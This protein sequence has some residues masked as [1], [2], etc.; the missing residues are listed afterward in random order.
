MYK[1]GAAVAGRPQHA[2][3]YADEDF[4]GLPDVSTSK[5]WVVA[6]LPGNEPRMYA[7]DDAVTP[8]EIK[9]GRWHFS[10]GWVKAPGFALEFPAAVDDAAHAL[11]S[12]ADER[13][14]LA[15]NAALIDDWRN[16]IRTQIDECSAKLLELEAELVQG[17]ADASAPSSPGWLTT[18]LGRD[19]AVDEDATRVT[20]TN[21]SSW[22]NHVSEPFTTD[23][24][25]LV[26]LFEID[27][28]P[29]FI[30]G[31]SYIYIYANPAHICLF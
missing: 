26:R 22:G 16:G 29:H 28:L 3:F 23:Q 14:A 9:K 5:K 19:I 31:P 12:I 1:Q 18:P 11:S 24:N 7:T 2:V 6:E 21:S 17:V 25:F 20:R 8:G 15:A 13:A 27:T 4:P 10:R 30:Y